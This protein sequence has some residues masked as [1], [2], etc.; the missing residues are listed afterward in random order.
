[1]STAAEERYGAPQLTIHRADL[2]AALEN[3]L[4]ENTIRF[5]SQVIAAEEGGSGAVAIL[6]DGTRFEADA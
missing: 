1:M 4:T 5:A 2:L 6:S 3:A